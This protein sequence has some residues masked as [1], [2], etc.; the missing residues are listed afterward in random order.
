MKLSL[1]IMTLKR[2]ESWIILGSRLVISLT[3]EKCNKNILNSWN[4]IA[5]FQDYQI[6]KIIQNIFC[7]I[8]III[9]ILIDFWRFG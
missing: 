1:D 8:F 2:H 3:E 7:Y 5:T 9:C 4:L 6:L